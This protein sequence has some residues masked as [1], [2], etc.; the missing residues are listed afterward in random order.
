M[1][2]TIPRYAARLNAFKIGADTYWPGKNRITTIDMLT[3]AST[4]EGLNAVDFNYPD[5]FDDCST[6]E[7]KQCMDDT[8]TQLNGMAMR[9]Y[10]D[11]AFKLGGFTH[12]EKRVRQTAIDI[13]LQGI[14][15]LTEIG[16]SLMTL[17]LGQDGFDYS[18]QVNYQQLWDYT[19]EALAVVCDHNK[20]VD[21]SLEY[22]PNEP[23]SYSLMPDV[24]SNLLALSELNRP[25]TGIT[26]DF[27]HVLYAEEMPAHAAAMVGRY[28]RLLGVHLN[29]G[30]GK[31]DDGLMVGSVHPVKTVELMVEMN[32]LNYDS[33][34]YFDTFP[35][36]SGLDPVAEAN[37]NVA[38]ANKLKA[39]A[40][41]L[42]QN[43]KLQ[44]AIANQDAPTSQS[45]VN[46]ALYGA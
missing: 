37:V 35:D 25:N 34:I 45:I 9:Y 4:V 20:D 38:M 28:S 21:I 40:D 23:R 11:P 15:K 46:R 29:D 32:R 22:K 36:L 8:A 18:F 19:L 44:A 5:H 39:V 42:T 17:W 31:R 2:K 13:T 16:G 14:D 27:A 3:R 10:T 1:N 24:G 43:A 12:P 41:S 30:Y 33:T 6:A 7:I 26:L